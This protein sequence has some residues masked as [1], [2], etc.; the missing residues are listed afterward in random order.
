[1][2]PAYNVKFLE[3]GDTVLMV[4]E[5]YAYG[6][7]QYKATTKEKALNWLTGQGWTI[8]SFA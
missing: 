3:F 5:N 4:W 8:K 2:K 6:K 1:M 7:H